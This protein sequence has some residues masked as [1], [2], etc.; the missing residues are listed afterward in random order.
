MQDFDWQKLLSPG[1]RYISFDSPMLKE[2]DAKGLLC[3]LVRSGLKFTEEFAKVKHTLDELNISKIYFDILNI[4]NY[5]LKVCKN[6]INI[7]LLILTYYGINFS[8]LLNFI[9]LILSIIVIIFH[10]YI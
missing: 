10:L 5:E 7:I 8:N 6:I 3:G 4:L 9:L 2:T 1:G